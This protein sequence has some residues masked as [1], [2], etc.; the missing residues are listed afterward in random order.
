MKLYELKVGDWQEG[1]CAAGGAGCTTENWPDTGAGVDFTVASLPT[2]AQWGKQLGVV[3]IVAFS[4]LIGGS[5]LFRRRVS[6][7]DALDARRASLLERIAAL[8]VN[9]GAGDAAA[10]RAALVAAL[11]EVCRKLDSLRDAGHNR[12]A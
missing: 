4:G 10:R 12:G 7:A 6:A 5:L 1:E 3:L 9:P 11:D 8:D 2:S